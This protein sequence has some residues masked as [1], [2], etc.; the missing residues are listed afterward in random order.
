MF[1]FVFAISNFIFCAIVLG[2]ILSLFGYEPSRGEM[3]ATDFIFFLLFLGLYIFL[4]KKF[5]APLQEKYNKKQALVWNEE[6][7]ATV[8]NIGFTYSPLRFQC[9]VRGRAKIEEF[10]LNSI[11][12]DKEGNPYFDVQDEF[13]NRI[14]FAYEN[15]T[16]QIHFKKKSFTTLEQFIKKATDYSY[17]DKF[18]KKRNKYLNQLK[19]GA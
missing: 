16:S 11:M 15:I 13:N 18:Q 5:K 9:R 7:L 19:M 12:I 10:K 8:L 4:W 17:W 1:T 2:A 6:G 14:A 3:Q